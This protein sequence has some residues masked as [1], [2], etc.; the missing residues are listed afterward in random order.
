MPG[1]LLKLLSERQATL[2]RKSTHECERM[3]SETPEERQT[4]LHW[5]RNRLASETPEERQTRLQW[6][7]YRRASEPPEERQTRIKAET[8]K[9]RETRLQQMS[10]NQHKRWQLKLLRRDN[11]DQIV[12]VQGTP[13][14]QLHVCAFRASNCFS[15]VSFKPRYGYIGY[16]NMLHF[17]VQK[18]FLAIIFTQSIINVCIVAVKSML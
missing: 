3:A 17:N 10:T 18:L 13:R 1:E 16:T 7:R 12:A 9:E 11:S 14:Q 5:M 15:S 4:R 6:M 8:P 2:Q